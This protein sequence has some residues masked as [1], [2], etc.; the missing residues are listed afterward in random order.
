MK[1]TITF[2][3][4]CACL[5]LASL[6][7]FAQNPATSAPTSQTAPARSPFRSISYTEYTDH[8]ELFAEYRPLIVGQPGR[9][10]THLT[11]L[12][13]TF[14]PYTEAEVSLQLIL[15]GKTVYQETIK[16]PAGPGIYR[17]PVKLDVAG[18]GQA[19]ITLK[20]P[21]N[22]EQFIV[23][24]VTVYPDEAVALAA[25]PKREPTPDIVAYAKEKGWLE[26]FATAPVTVK[27]KKVIVPSTAVLTDQGSSYVYVQLDPEHFRKQVVETGTPKDNTLEIKSGLKSGDRIITLGADKIK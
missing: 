8:S 2:A 15:D 19:T 5:C 22:T 25:Q 26:T 12:G 21:A 14:K 13:E 3:S 7:G 6:P 9:F 16:Q 23:K 11:M 4:F 27:K 10:T 24:N 18:T 20:M 1:K 17:F